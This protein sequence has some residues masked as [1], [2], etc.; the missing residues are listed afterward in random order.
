[1]RRQLLILALSSW[2]LRAMRQTSSQSNSCWS[3][4]PNSATRG[5]R[6][7]GHPGRAPPP[8]LTGRASSRIVITFALFR[9]AM[10]WFNK[11]ATRTGGGSVVDEISGRPLELES[12]RAL[13]ANSLTD[14]APL[15]TLHSGFRG[16]PPRRFL[17]ADTHTPEER[18]DL[19][20]ACSRPVGGLQR[21]PRHGSAD[22]AVL[23]AASRGSHRRRRTR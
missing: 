17:A 16:R 12:L 14:R 20:G 8:G 7:H 9:P 18:S 23:P 5:R 1:M 21:H 13:A 6:R 2:H 11:S 4:N 10:R 22:W 19:R 3:R 15:R